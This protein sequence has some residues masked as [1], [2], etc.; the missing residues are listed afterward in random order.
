MRSPGLWYHQSVDGNQL[1]CLFSAD[2]ISATTQMS[3]NLTGD[4]PAD[5]NQLAEAE[6]KKE[7]M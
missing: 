5:Q 1:V 2:A 3:Q 4:K 6:L 7:E